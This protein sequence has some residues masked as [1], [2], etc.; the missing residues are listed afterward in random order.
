MSYT[1]ENTG[2][3][4]MPRIGGRMNEGMLAICLAK[5]RSG[6]HDAEFYSDKI[7]FLPFLLILFRSV[8]VFLV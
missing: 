1:E 6:N 2:S 4:R 7:D 3:T 8:K 5:Y